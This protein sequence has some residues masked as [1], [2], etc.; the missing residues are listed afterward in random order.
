MIASIRQVIE[1]FRKALVEKDGGKY[2]DWHENR[3][4]SSIAGT[5]FLLGAMVELD[6]PAYKDDMRKMAD[7]IISLQEKNGKLRTDFYRP[8][9]DIDQLYYPGETLLAMIRY[10]KLAKYEPAKMMV[11]KAFP[12]YLEFWD[13]NKE[14]PFVPWQI[15]AYQELYQFSP[16]KK[17]A[18][19][20]FD[21]MD[22]MI[23]R[24]TPVSAEA[25]H[26]REGAFSTQFAS[27][28]VYSEGLSQAYALALEVKDKKRSELYGKTL[29]GT[30]GYLLGLQFKK[31]DTYWV[32][33]P[34]KVVGATALR[35]DINELRLDAT[36]HSI[37]AIHYSTQLISKK[38]WNSI[39]R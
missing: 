39:V 16:K 1:T 2:L 23:K 34:E 7:A 10:Y 22:W 30:L 21:L 19:F 8:L 24:Y 5:A 32:K 20:V 27:T 15:R 12:F 6:I 36:Y 9:R 26:G 28:A 18:D 3:P 17:Y 33:R 35:P 4:V 11:E 29:K 38:H 13:D 25:G 37:S 31:E 14:G